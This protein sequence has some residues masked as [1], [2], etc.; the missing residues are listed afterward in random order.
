M[1]FIEDYAKNKGFM[2]LL[3]KFALRTA[4]VS[5]CLNGT[6]T[7]NAGT[8]AKSERNSAGSLISRYIKKLLDKTFIMHI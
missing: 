6:G 8:T 3:Q 1:Q 2:F 7:Q 5:V 4:K